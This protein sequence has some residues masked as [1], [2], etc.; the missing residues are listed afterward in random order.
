MIHAVTVAAIDVTVDAEYDPR[1]AF[2]QQPAWIRNNRR[3]LRVDCA[4]EK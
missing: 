2:V 1:K 4:E 3:H